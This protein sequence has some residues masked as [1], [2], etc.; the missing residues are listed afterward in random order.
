MALEQR[1]TRELL[2][3]GILGGIVA[4]IVFLLAEMVMAVALGGD[5]L[6]PLRVI[7]S[8]LLST[9]AFVPD[10]PLA[11][12]AVVAVIVHLVLSAVYGLIFTYVLA[13]ADQLDA[14]PGVLLLYGTI[15]GLLLWVVNLLII[16]PF[17]F[18]QFGMINAFWQGFVAHT[19]FY[20]TALG[21]YVAATRPGAAAALLR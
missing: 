13:Y 14:S 3:R 6:D 19:V 15:F 10:Y 4:G 17:A 1:S 8:I 20:G 12:I 5:I 18:P 16:A 2:L 21:G 9:V 11:A 7:G